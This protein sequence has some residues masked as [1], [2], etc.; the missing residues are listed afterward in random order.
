MT[1]KMNDHKMKMENVLGKARVMEEEKKQATQ[2]YDAKN[3]RG[4]TSQLS[5]TAQKK[6]PY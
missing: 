2:Q 5:Q 1:T 3:K 6:P 4:L